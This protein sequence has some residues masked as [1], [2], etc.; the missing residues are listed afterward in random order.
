[1]RI[2]FRPPWTAFL[3]ALGGVFLFGSEKP[4]QASGPEKI[5]LDHCCIVTDPH[6]ASYVQYGVE[7]LADY[8]ASVT[9]QKTAFGAQA[10]ANARTC[11]AVG[12]EQAR[13]VFGEAPS[14]AELGE[15]GYLLKSVVKDGKHYIVVAGAT[16]HGTKTG[17]VAL[18]RRIQVQGRT[19]YL[20]GPLAV[21]G[22]PTWAKRGM[23]FN[24]WAFNY[25]YT[26]RAWREE[27]WQ[28]YLDILA[29]QGVNLF[30]LWPFIEIMPV[31]LSPEDQAY[32]EECR[33]VID[34]AQRKHGMEVWI[35][36]CT[37]RVAQDRCG[38]ADPRRR[39]YWRPSQKDLDPSK[40][41][42][43][44]AILQSRAA[45]YRIVNNVDGVCNIDSDPGY[46]PGSSLDAYVKVLRGYR[47]L[48]DRHNLQGKR[49]KL[50]NWMW[51]GWG[52]ASGQRKD[53]DQHQLATI[54]SLKQ[55][56]PEPWTL[57][58][59]MED[60][61]PLCQGQQVLEKT[62]LLPYGLIE[63]EPSY[64]ATN[65]QIGELRA[66]LERQ[67][68]RY[69]GLAGVMGNVQT[70]LLQFPHMFFFTSVLWDA[71]FRKQPEKE[72]LLELSRHLYPEHREL[73]ADSFLALKG[74]DPARI[75]SLAAKLDGILR[76]DRLGRAGLFGRKLFPDYRIVAQSLLLQLKLLATRE[77]MLQQ[78]SPEKDVTALT[79]MLLDHCE[80]YLAWEAAHGWHTVWG[81]GGL[82][83]ASDARF[84][85]VAG[86]LARA[87]GDPA[88]VEAHLERLAKT[89]AAKHEKRAVDE[90]C[91][92]PLKR[93]VLSALPIVTLAQKA[94]ASASVVPD[95]VRYPP[96]AANDGNVATLYWPGALVQ[97]NREWLQLTWDAPQTFD[98]VVV[99]FLR[100][101]SMPGRTIHLQKEVAPG[102]WE[103]FATTVIPSEPSAPHAMALFRLPRR[104]TLDKIRVV[105]LLDLFEIEVR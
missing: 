38:V 71:E 17:L 97:N 12:L 25:P 3:A 1:M 88:K 4:V 82:P 19:A 30:Y 105:N 58:A 48:L 32:L 73:I 37:N 14:T 96:S 13:R 85:K 74:T 33:R 68:T 52:L 65:V 59:G 103:D 31:P 20:D 22:K 57:V 29:Y 51:F 75:E 28:H 24:G 62:V 6:P 66:L 50:V 23:H 61:L 41:E 27:D 21:V 39:P 16:P 60:Y 10:G 34:Y 56:L 47:D 94:K 42:H 55:A 79:Q 84:P 102:K 46:C 54:Q 83:L 99:R 64:P 89:L 100:H 77:R 18:A 70:P 95:P 80:A 49:A 72:V 40:A 69:P 93:I 90:G 87:L 92:A 9:G 78:A 15:E 81:W 67:I 2:T 98:Q 11:I 8:L 26:F 7:D 104:V 45:L 53:R 43:L 36:H 76:Q 44:Q 101:P 86:Q 91:I 35:M 63:G 5:P